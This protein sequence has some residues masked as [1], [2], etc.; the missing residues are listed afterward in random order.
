MPFK[1]FPQLVIRGGAVSLP[2]RRFDVE[3]AL[4]AYGELVD[5]LTVRFGKEEMSSVSSKWGSLKG[6]I[7][8][9]F[10]DRERVLNAWR[11]WVPSYE[12]LAECVTHHIGP[13]TARAFVLG[14]NWTVYDPATDALTTQTGGDPLTLD[15]SPYVE[16]GGPMVGGDLTG[17]NELA[18]NAVR[19][20]IVGELVKSGFVLS[21]RSFGDSVNFRV[22][23]RISFPHEIY[24][25]GD[26][27]RLVRCVAPNGME[28]PTLGST[29]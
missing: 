29:S 18:F 9:P 19:N 8:W 22:I 13:I 4:S 17:L 16:I 5:R 26:G 2:G 28:L 23:L 24:G 21:T 25:A 20:L 3:R 12:V 10:P 1:K 6:R 11:S 14:R 7:G 15:S 27:W